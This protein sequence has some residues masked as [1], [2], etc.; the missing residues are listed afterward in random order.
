MAY[1]NASKGVNKQDGVNLHTDLTLLETSASSALKDTRRISEARRQALGILEK[2]SEHI[3]EPGA[4]VRF[5]ACLTPP[6]GI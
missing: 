1:Q 4:A 5:N 6:V 2:I 3:D